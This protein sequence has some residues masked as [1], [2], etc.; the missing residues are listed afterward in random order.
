M[1]ETSEER[2]RLLK[3]GVDEKFIE[4]LYIKCNHFKIVGTPVLFKTDK[5]T[6]K[7]SC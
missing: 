5:N 7:Q 1:L 3:A 4:E 6:D 2:I